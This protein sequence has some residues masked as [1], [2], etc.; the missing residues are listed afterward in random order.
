MHETTESEVRTS[1]LTRRNRSRLGIVGGGQLARMTAMA[2]LELG[3]EVFV[4]ERNSLS[5]AMS[6]AHRALVGDWDRAEDLLALA[7]LADAVT[8]ENEF[9][10]AAKLALLEERGHHLRPGAATIAL[11]QDKL[12][13]KETLSAAGLPVSPFRAASSPDEVVAIA[14]EFGWPLVLKARRNGYDGK[15]N[16]TLRD[17]SDVEAAWQRLG[18]D[19]GRALYVE[20]YCPFA[21]EL[22]VIITRTRDG[23]VATYPLV[24]TVQRDHICHVVRAP[25]AVS[26]TIAGRAVDV[27]ERAVAAVGA[28]GSFGVEMFLTAEGEVTINEL[29]PRVHNSGHYTLDACVCSQF[30]NHVRAVFDWPLGSPAMRE[31]AAV[32]INLLGARRGPGHVTGL[33]RALAVP[34]AH[35]HI[36]GKATSHPGRKL[37]HVTAVGATV[38]EAEAL[39]RRC[40]DEIQ[41]GSEE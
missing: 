30:E 28:V 35:V 10:D 21:T 20:A 36:Y 12:T 41:F 13:Q 5:P 34:G 7:T 9:I 32:M 14:R 26:G 19:E 2:A 11:V 16:A 15:G 38:A 37:G 39:A 4:L 23:S 33:E 40:A 8:L 6:L 27:A 31:P 29:A 18:G 17:P 25:A 3:C 22:A 24:E 1:A